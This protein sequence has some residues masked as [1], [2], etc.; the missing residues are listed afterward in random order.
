M[1]NTDYRLYLPIMKT[2]QSI[3]PFKAGFVG[4]THRHDRVFKSR[5]CASPKPTFRVIA[6]EALI[7]PG[8]IIMFFGNRTDYKLVCRVFLVVLGVM[9]L[10]AAI[11]LL[12]NKI[13]VFIYSTHHEFRSIKT[14]DLDRI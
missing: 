7:I 11:H 3:R 14:S 4:E 2:W 13:A 1:K 9:M 5:R 10:H 6:R 8:F 12:P